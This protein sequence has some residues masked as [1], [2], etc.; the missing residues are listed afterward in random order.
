MKTY[1]S[2]SPPK[3]KK[4][5]DESEKIKYFEDLAEQLSFKVKDLLLE[6]RKHTGYI[7]DT[8]LNPNHLKS[9][10]AV[11][12]PLHEYLCHFLKDHKANIFI[13]SSQ[14]VLREDA[15]F[16]LFID[17]VDGSLNWDR[18][19]GNP[20][21]VA[22]FSSKTNDVTYQDLEYGF[23]KNFRTNDV[24]QAKNGKSYYYS[25]LTDKQIEIKC[26]G[27]VDLK[28][29][30]GCLR[31]GY[32]LATNQFAATAPLF[33]LAK[34]IRSEENTGIELCYI[35]RDALDFIVEARKASDDFN[36]LAYPIIKNS[37]A[38]IS[39][40]N[41]AGFSGKI[42]SQTGKQDFIVSNSKKLHYEILKQI[43]DFKEKKVFISNNL[44][45]EII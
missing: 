43:S 38:I 5:C 13:E 34:D 2:F 11:D 16:S 8:N 4:N 9:C 42:I 19:I 10:H 3:I 6:V 1:E 30:R 35:A 41:G 22:A 39:D 25:S 26:Q 7:G 29:A 33:L 20:C 12:K 28:N 27:Q 31:P 24:Y 15:E 44:K 14:P 45:I 37:G 17:P 40:L 36:L 23:V 21:F 32:S 18:E